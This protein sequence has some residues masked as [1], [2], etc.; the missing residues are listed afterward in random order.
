[1]EAMREGSAAEEAVIVAVAGRLMEEADLLPL[2][3]RQRM[4]PHTAFVARCTSD[5]CNR[6]GGA[7]REESNLGRI[8]SWPH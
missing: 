3:P 7:L 5:C 1:M 6:G 4:V 2:G 8:L